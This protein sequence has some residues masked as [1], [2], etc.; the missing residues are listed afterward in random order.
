MRTLFAKVTLSILF[1]A[2]AG[3]ANAQGDHH[4]STPRVQHFPAPVVSGHWSHQGHGHHNAG[5][6]RRQAYHAGLHDVAANFRMV[7][8]NHDGLATR[9]EI[10]AFRHWQQRHHGHG[11]G[12]GYGR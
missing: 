9:A 2:G 10:I 1:A 11:Y 8:R 6:S 3:I 12:Y 5:I 7:D 4:P